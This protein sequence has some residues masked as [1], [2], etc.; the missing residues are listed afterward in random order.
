[1]TGLYGLYTIVGCVFDSLDLRGRLA[2]LA[3]FGD[4]VTPFEVGHGGGK[5]KGGKRGDGEGTKRAHSRMS[6]P[7]RVL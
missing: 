3:V 1:M 5:G 7:S 6:D 4:A 2:F